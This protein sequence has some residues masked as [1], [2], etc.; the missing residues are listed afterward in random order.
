[1]T[2]IIRIDPDGTITECEGDDLLFVAGNHFPDGLDIVTLKTP[3]GAPPEFPHTDE[4]YLVGAL[5][6]WS[7]TTHT[8]VNPKAWALYGRSPLI[9]PIFVAHDSYDDGPGDEGEARPP[10]PPEF[11]ERM[12]EDWVRSPLM[13]RSTM[14]Q[15]AESEGFHWP[16]ED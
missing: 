2:Y 10:L 5:G 8:Y 9:G 6:Q 7:R 14:R 11:I 15:I 1:M 16:W 12:R 13:L 3:E 4:P